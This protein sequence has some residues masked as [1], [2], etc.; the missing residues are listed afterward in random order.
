MVRHEGTREARPYQLTAKIYD[1][2][3]E[4]AWGDD[5][6]S[7]RETERGSPARV[8]FANYGGWILA[9]APIHRRFGALAFRFRAPADFG[10]FL[11]VRVDSTQKTLFP[12]VPVRA[13]LRSDLTDGWTEVLI[14]FAVLN[15]DNLPFDRVVFRAASS[16]GPEW[17]GIDGIGFTEASASE[18]K[19]ITDAPSADATL[20]VDCRAKGQPINPLIYGIA[21]DARLDAKDVHK[22]DLGASARRWG[23]NA[24]SRYNWELGNAWNTANDYYFENV[25]YT[26]DPSF[27]YKSFLQDNINHHAQSVITVPIIGWVAKDITS[28]SLPV[29]EYGPQKGVAQNRPA[30]DGRTP[31]GKDITPGP[32]TRTSIPA[33]PEF[34]KRWVEAVRADDAKRGSRSVQ[35]YILDNEPMLWNGTHRDVHPDPVTYDELLDRTLKYGAAVRAADADGVIAG[36]ALWGW[37]A[38]FFSAK[39]SAAGFQLKPDRLAHGD[40]PLLPWYLRQ[41]RDHEK[42]TGTRILD[43]VDVHFYPMASRVGGKNGSVDA[44]AAALRIRSTRALWDPTYVDESWIGEAIQLIPRLKQWIQENYP[45]RGIQIGEYNFGAEQHISSGLATAEALGR[46]GQGG[47]TAAF[48]WTYPPKDSPPDWAFRAYRNFDGAGGRFLDLSLP[49]VAPAGTSAFASRDPSGRHLVVLALNLSA[50]QAVRPKL[51]LNGC[52]AVVDEKVFQYTADAAGLVPHPRAT[53]AA[54]PTVEALPPS[55]ITVFDLQIQNAP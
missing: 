31:A 1:G 54:L 37:P 14:P 44:Q 35:T 39:D 6:W 21:Y 12:R 5:G 23:G 45:G 43:V 17:V 40:V 42:Q 22:W 49:T 34:I 15:P 26:N 50:D 3:F 30:G 41:L 8:N 13:E 2:G 36:P 18:A 32:P 38:Y 28:F 24:T 25:N 9:H 10:D 16:V 7:P 46:F 11:E 29:S 33:P 48:Y 20:I 19:V 52:S 55:S 47:V 27:T 4:E 51:M 53:G